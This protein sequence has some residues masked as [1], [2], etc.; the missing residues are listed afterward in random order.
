MLLLPKRYRDFKG[1]QILI[2]SRKLWNKLAFFLGLCFLKGGLESLFNWNFFK[3]SK[4][5]GDLLI[6]A[7]YLFGC[8]F[9][10]KIQMREN[11]CTRPALL[12][13]LFE[14][15]ALI[16]IKYQI[17]SLDH[18]LQITQDCVSCK[19]E[20]CFI[21]EQLKEGKHAGSDLLHQ[22]QLLLCIHKSDDGVQDRETSLQDWSGA[23]SVCRKSSA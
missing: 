4:H 23:C 5:F 12:T 11:I 8:M 19:I 10:L 13:S 1:K 20:A 14:Q 17:V 6:N 18:S 9:S 2:D 7:G 21:L 22:P 3:S 15:S 16:G